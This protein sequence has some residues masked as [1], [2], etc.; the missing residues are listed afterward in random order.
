MSSQITSSLRKRLQAKLPYP[1][2]SLVDLAF[3]FWWSWSPEQL[4]IFRNFSPEMWEQHHH[5]P[6]KLL[7]SIPVERLAQLATDPHY[8]K[9]V[10]ALAN[11]FKQYM[12]ATDTWASREAPQ[13]STQQPV[14][15]F[16][17]EYRTNWMLSHSI[18]Y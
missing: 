3:N 14:A 5:N 1:L 8:I 18:G 12:Q 9:R 13:Y 4:S 2:H 6:V 16:S 7:E 15:Y 10:E 11:Q 17:I